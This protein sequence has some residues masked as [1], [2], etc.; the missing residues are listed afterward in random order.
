MSRFMD[1]V[2]E[3]AEFKTLEEWNNPTPKP[4]LWSLPEY[5]EKYRDIICDIPGE[6]ENLMNDKGTNT[7]NN[8]PRALIIARVEAQVSLLEYLYKNNLL[9]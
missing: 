7:F 4:K 2:F 3:H 6:I 8:A 5:L 9:S 1:E